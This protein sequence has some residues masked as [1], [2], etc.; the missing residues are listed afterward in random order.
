MIWNFVRRAAIVC[1]A[2]SFLV[3]E[4]PESAHAADIFYVTMSDN[5][6]RKFDT[7]GNS[8]G[9]FANTGMSDPRGL[10][11][12]ASGNLY[13]ANYDSNSLSKYDP[14]GNY[15]PGQSI[16]QPLNFS[17]GVL[18]DQAGAIYVS[19]E[20][21][22]RIQKYDAA[23]NLLARSQALN[24]PTAM[25]FDSDG[26]IRVANRTGNTVFKYDTDLV[27]LSGTISTNT[28]RPRGLAMD[29]SGNIYVA[30]SFTDDISKFT[31]SGVLLD[32]FG[33]SSTMD[34]P[35]GLAFDSSGYLYVASEGTNQIVKY[36]TAGEY[37]T[38][39]STGSISPRFISFGGTPV[40]EPGS[41][42]LGA[43]CVVAAILA[44]RRGRI[45]K[46]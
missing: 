4:W 15:L 37:V 7:D 38:A 3:A 23:G 32:R 6:V 44:K 41:L 14:N 5:T 11:F 2:L 27:M 9:I 19:N 13:V 28:N 18:I 17:V 40:P 46:R 31:S 43:I 30:N 33:S 42:A 10:A 21:N 24:T 25:I 39:W 20:S 12:D 16:A 34:L 26:N 45:A 8:L 29:S 36:T 35:Y 1:A 22:A